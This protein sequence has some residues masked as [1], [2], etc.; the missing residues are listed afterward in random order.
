MFELLL[1]SMLTVLPDYLFRR[2]V[3]GKRVGR[4]INLYSVWF[5]LRWGITACLIL[6]V[7]LITL[8]FYFHPATRNVTAVFR[9]V[10]I[11]PEANG[12]VAE[13][14]VTVNEKVAAGQP[15]FRLDD[16]EQRAAVTTAERRIAEVEADAVVAQSELA[17][18]DGQIQDA[19]SALAQAQD[20]L[21]VQTELRRRN[22]DTIAQ[23]AIE[24]LQ[25]VVDGR[26]GALDAAMASKATQQTRIASALPAAKASAEA[27][28]AQ[29][30]VELDKTLVRAGVAGTVQQFV[31]RP[32]D[33]VNP[34]IRSAGLLV[35][36][37]AGETALIAGF[38]Q[39]E[40]QVMK[41]GMIAE[42]TCAAKPFTILPM[43]VS[44]VQNVIAAGQL[45]PTDQ[46]ID[47]Q[48]LSQ[49]GTLTVFLEPLFAGEM[50][51]VPPGSSC[52]AN[53]YT[54]NHDALADPTIGTGRWLFLHVVDTVGLV[55][56]MILRMQA[57]MLPVQ[58]L[59]L[60]GH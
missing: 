46:L 9:T 7:L 31:L 42:A 8:I 53:A 1:C 3:Q 34:M 39:I 36:E 10:T 19:R 15:L 37:G 55:H 52:I 45:R 40:A 6:T 59:V 60:G 56:A 2:Y 33:V 35:P 51:G 22:P 5:E 17:T 21:D 54:N 41:V 25:V 18:A 20:E 24:K 27:E 11:L 44:Q 48:N 4:E 29:A 12:R 13:V 58:T 50:I 30:Q 47:V 32:G 43:V 28:L 57:M 38:G 16:A 26:Q 23:R 14:Y 49:P